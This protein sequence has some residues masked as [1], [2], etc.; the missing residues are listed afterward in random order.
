MASSQA[1]NLTVVRLGRMAYGPALDVQLRALERVKAARDDDRPVEYLLLVEHQPPVITM[2]RGGDRKN[3]LASAARL[4]ELGIELHE[5]SR[6]GDVT[7]HGPGQ[8]VAYPVLDLDRHGR[9]VHR[10][11][12][13]IEQAVLGL[14]DGLGLEG[15]RDRQ[16]TGVWV[17]R[18]KV[19]AIGVAITRWVTYHG[20]ALNVATELDRFGLIVPCGIRDRGVTSLEKLLGCKV[21]IDDVAAKLVE[22]FVRRFDFAGTVEGRASDI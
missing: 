20:L 10:Y 18:E 5:S 11:L 16:Y 12:R 22:E 2:G 8:L 15:R 6:G 13:D 4:A 21:A 9:D 7:Y 19:C 14:L 3:L 1:H 17:G